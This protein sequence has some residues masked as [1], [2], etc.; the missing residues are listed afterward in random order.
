MRLNQD[1]SNGNL[2]ASGTN[3]TT[4][5]NNYQSCFLGTTLNPTATSTLPVSTAAAPTILSWTY[6]CIVPLSKIH[7]FFSKI[8][9][10]NS[11]QGFELRLQTNVGSPAQNNWSQTFST[12]GPCTLASSFS[13]SS[14][15]TP[16]TG[17]TCGA[18]QSFGHTCPFMISPVNVSGTT[19]TNAGTGLAVF[20]LNSTINQTI[21][22][23]VSSNIGYNNP[24]NS[25][26]QQPCRLWIPMITYNPK[27][28]NMIL[29][30]PVFKMLYNDYYID[31]ILGVSQGSQ[32]SRLYSIQISRPRTIYIIPFLSTTSNNGGLTAPV[33]PYQQLTSSAPTT[34]SNVKLRNFNFQIGGSNIFVNPLQYNSD[35][36]ENNLLQLLGKNI[37]NGNSFKSELY[38]GVVKKRDWE[39]A[40][41]VYAFNVCKS[42]DLES[43]NAT[44]NFQ[45]SFT[46]ESNPINYSF[47]FLWCIDYQNEIYLDRMTGTLTSER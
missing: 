42:V 43:D 18:V 25:I 23:T 4:L 3:T 47:D 36:Y 5:A 33:P 21:T 8:P 30:Q 34:C 29:N 14:V 35:Y 7:D 20:P 6:N 2:K 1:L 13:Q 16:M 26:P 44:K 45:I 38:S 19:Q 39:L 9:S 24:T 22:L 11:T 37:A 32:V 12:G 46:V 27:Y 40:Y 41:G 17:L 28:T 31:T 15:A 10:I